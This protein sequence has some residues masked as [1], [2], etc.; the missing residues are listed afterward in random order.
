MPATAS[1]A[2]RTGGRRPKMTPVLIDEARRMYDLKQFTMAEIASSCGVTPMTV[3]ATSASTSR[4]VYRGDRRG[5]PGGTG[6][7]P[8]HGRGRRTGPGPRRR[9]GGTQRSSRSGTRQAEWPPWQ[10]LTDPVE[11]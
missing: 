4:P 9:N 11:P 8:G 5:H 6:R 3:Y 2:H 10:R 7:L 1:G